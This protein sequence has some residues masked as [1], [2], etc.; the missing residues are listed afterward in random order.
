M[1]WQNTCV[2]DLD[3]QLV[4]QTTADGDT[5]TWQYDAYGRVIGHTHLSGAVYSYTYDANTGLLTGESDNWSPTAQG[6]STPAYVTAPVTTPNSSTDTYF[7]DGQLATQTYADGSTYSYSYDANGN[8]VRQEATTV[9]GNGQAV[10]T[11][12][13]T[14][15]DSHNRLSHVVATNLLT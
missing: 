14:T 12:T 15:Y 1:A 3:G 2:Y 9:D 7:A 13:T 11:V 10:H 4:S 6:Q 5:E 8:Q